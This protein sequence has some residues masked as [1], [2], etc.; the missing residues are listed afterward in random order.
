MYK[1]EP[2][3]WVQDTTLYISPMSTAVVELPDEWAAVTSE[4]LSGTL[5]LD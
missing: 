1:R 4:Q 5:G 2:R 3:E